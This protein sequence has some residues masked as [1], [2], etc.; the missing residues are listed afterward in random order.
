MKIKSIYACDVMMMVH[1]ISI[2]S[3]ISEDA[4]DKARDQ[5]ADMVDDG[6]CLKYC[7]AKLLQI[8][9]FY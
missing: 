6:S 7:V 4:S 8:Q 9:Y 1:F 3:G 2:V 5:S